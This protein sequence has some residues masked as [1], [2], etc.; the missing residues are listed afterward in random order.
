MNITYRRLAYRCANPVQPHGFQ[1]FFDEM[2]PERCPR[3]GAFVG[4][5]AIH[6]LQ[7]T[8]PISVTAAPFVRPQL[9]TPVKK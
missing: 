7:E 5:T 9:S 2:P 6:K 3:C 1:L 4:R 8:T